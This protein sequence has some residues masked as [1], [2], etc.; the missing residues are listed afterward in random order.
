MFEEDDQS[1][2]TLYPTNGRES[3]MR[4]VMSSNRQEEILKAVTGWP[5]VT[6]EPHRYGGIEF[7]LGRR[8]L[9]HLDG[10]SL[11]DVP[12]PRAVRDEL[13][14]TARA[15][16]HHILPESGWISFRIHSSDD[17][18]GALELLRLSYERA[19]S[20]STHKK[21]DTTILKTEEQHA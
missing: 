1:V 10:D 7:R 2:K 4:I 14:Q 6:T 11:L 12:F 9:G 3:K 18:N 8:E 21:S 15:E 17:V 16:K 13:L 5:G 19:V 20:A